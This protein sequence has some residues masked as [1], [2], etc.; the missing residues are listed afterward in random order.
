MRST[1]FF[2]ES[3]R[4]LPTKPLPPD[5]LHGLDS[6]CAR[7][8]CRVGVEGASFRDCEG[9]DST[10]PGAQAASE[11]ADVMGRLMEIG[12]TVIGNRIPGSGLLRSE[13][14]LARRVL[15]L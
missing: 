9:T 11:S 7:Y 4:V 1:L 5:H 3:L 14:E 6:R 8:P 10:S 2:T 12:E 13:G 15:G